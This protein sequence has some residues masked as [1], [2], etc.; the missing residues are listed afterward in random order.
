MHILGRNPCFSAYFENRDLLIRLHPTTETK[1]KN[2]NDHPLLPFLSKLV[3]VV[4]SKKGTGDQFRVE[5]YPLVRVFRTQAKYFI[6]VQPID[7]LLNDL[8]LIF[9]GTILFGV[10][11]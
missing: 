2:P 4:G 8:L 11:K 6:R 3:M 9:F 1:G 5:V 10:A 7:A